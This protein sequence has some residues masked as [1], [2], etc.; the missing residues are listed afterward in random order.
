MILLKLLT[1]SSEPVEGVW[2]LISIHPEDIPAPSDYFFQVVG[3]LSGFSPVNSGT[4]DEY[5]RRLGNWFRSP[6]VPRTDP[7]S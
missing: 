3:S 5:T 6:G 4:K 7:A 1:N 2:A